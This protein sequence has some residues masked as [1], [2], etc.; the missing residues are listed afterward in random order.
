MEVRTVQRPQKTSADGWSQRDRLET[1]EYAGACSP[2][3]T[4]MEQRDGIDLIEKI[5]D[6]NNLFNACKKVRANKG[7]PVSTK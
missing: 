7:V 5:V 2:V 1:E 4:E 3:F 6:I